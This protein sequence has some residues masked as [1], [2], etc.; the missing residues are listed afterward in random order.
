QLISVRD[1]GIL[2][3]IGKF[4]K[5]KDLYEGAKKGIGAFILA[6]IDFAI[7]FLDIISEVAK[8]VSLSLRLFGNMYAGQVL[9]TVI[10]GGFAYGLPAIWMVMGTLS[11]VVQTLVFALLVTA[12]YTI[13]VKMNKEAV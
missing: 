7:G 5:I 12:Y 8:V 11:V 3:Y 2:G 6:L 9:A 4:I 1:Y 13:S 10:L